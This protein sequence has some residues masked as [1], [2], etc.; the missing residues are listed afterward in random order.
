MTKCFFNE[1][2]YCE[3]DCAAYNTNFAGG[4]TFIVK[5]RQITESIQAASSAV[6]SYF[7]K[8]EKG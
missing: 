8:I 5:V 3:S 2:R 7:N 4:C 6:F 1:E